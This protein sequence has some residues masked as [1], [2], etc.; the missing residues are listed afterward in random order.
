MGKEEKEEEEEEEEK[1]EGG[2]GWEGVWQRPRLLGGSEE[3][4]SLGTYPNPLSCLADSVP[5]VK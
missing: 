4:K 3:R 2:V 1:E 5:F